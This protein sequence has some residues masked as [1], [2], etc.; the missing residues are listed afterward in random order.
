MA[1]ELLIRK[2]DAELLE[3]V[4]IEVFEAENVQ[5]ANPGGFCAGLGRPQNFVE[6]IDE[7]IEDARVQGFAQSVSA[8]Q[9][10]CTR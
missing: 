3:G 8:V 9:G 5:K 6:A 10:L 1:L 7:P 4:F 2:V